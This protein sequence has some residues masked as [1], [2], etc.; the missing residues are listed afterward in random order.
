ML[1]INNETLM[2]IL[3]TKHTFHLFNL[4]METD[5]KQ[6]TY[7]VKENLKFQIILLSQKDMRN[8]YNLCDQTPVTCGHKIASY[9]LLQELISV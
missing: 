5:H 2:F 9:H 6:S 4:T 8:L 7:H 3:Q 1:I